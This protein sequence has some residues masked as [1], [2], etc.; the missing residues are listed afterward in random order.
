MNKPKRILIIRTDRIGDVALSLPVITALRRQFPDCEIGMLVQPEI[1]PVVED[2][3]DLTEVLTDGECETG[4]GGFFRLVRKIR[5][6]NWN[7]AL[8]LH[9]T[10]RLAA[11]L[12]FAGIPI[13]V[14]TAYR[15][16][17][18]L[19]NRRVREHRKTGH[20]H[21]AEFNLSL[22]RLI[23]VENHPIAFNLPVRPEAKQSVARWLEKQGVP[24][25]H[26]RVVL[27]P[28]SRGSARD[29]PAGRFAELADRL[30]QKNGAVVFMTGTR[31][32]ESL[33]RSLIVKTHGTVHN[34]AGQFSL[35][36]LIAFLGQ[37]DLYIS[38]S[39]GPLHLAAALGT[40][41]LGL[42]PNLRPAS[43]RRWGPWAQSENC[44]TAHYPECVRCSPKKCGHIQCMESISV[45][46]VWQKAD[47]IIKS[48]SSLN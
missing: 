30:I 47:Q 39:T 10:F 14:G 23:G 21:E 36:E 2:H 34:L 16:Y 37:T 11:S 25:R 29:W 22:A 13:R 44:I 7:T 40:K 41:V 48:R 1:V 9:P 20:R 26:P 46:E 12:A 4:A 8:L 43:V 17:S 27:H 45:E 28:G 38:N 33:I 42:Y 18:F 3:P 32:E 5:L 15:F 35:K 24:N 31:E 6:G 19:F